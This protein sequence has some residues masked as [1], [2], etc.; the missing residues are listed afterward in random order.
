[1]KYATKVTEPERTNDLNELLRLLRE[2]ADRLNQT[3]ER[4]DYEVK[5]QDG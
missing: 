5:N 3:D 4:K 2:I 1:M